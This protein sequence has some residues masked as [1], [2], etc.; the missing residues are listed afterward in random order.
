MQLTYSFPTSMSEYSYQF[1]AEGFEPVTPQQKNSVLKAMAAI[2]EFADVQFVEGGIT[3]RIKI[4]Q[5]DVPPTSYAYMPGNY[6]DM[7]SDIWLGRSCG[8]PDIDLYSKY[9]IWHELGHSLGLN[10]TTLPIEYS[11]MTSNQF[12]PSRRVSTYMADDILS[13]Q[14]IYGANYGTRTGNTSYKPVVD[15]VTTIWDGN[16]I[17][18]LNFSKFSEVSINLN[19]GELSQSGKTKVYMSYLFEDDRSLIENA[20]GTDGKDT[21]IGNSAINTFT[22][23]KGKDTFYIDHNDIITD[24]QSVDTVFYL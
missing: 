16:G 7:E 17:D 5:S 12:N 19:P 8:N 1:E 14:E 13:L 23:G 2:S 3:A 10:H 22:G 4:S 24:L 9:Q 11:I 18:T 21:F 20:I 6:G 15:S